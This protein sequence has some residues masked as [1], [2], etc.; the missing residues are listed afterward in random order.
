MSFVPV[1]GSILHLLIRGHSV[2]EA[3]QTYVRNCATFVAF[4]QI[5]TVSSPFYI[6]DSGPNADFMRT[7]FRG[8]KR[9]MFGLERA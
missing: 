3:C 4:E 8:C 7:D 2:Q 6:R 9:P 5:E 1:G